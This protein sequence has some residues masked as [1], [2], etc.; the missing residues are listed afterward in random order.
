MHYCASSPLFYPWLQTN[1]AEDKQEVLSFRDEGYL[2]KTGE[3][4]QTPMAKKG[5]QQTQKEDM[6]EKKVD[7]PINMI[8]IFEK[9]RRLP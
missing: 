8:P 9:D 4:T 5:N 6:H 7:Y 3:K 2:L 1:I